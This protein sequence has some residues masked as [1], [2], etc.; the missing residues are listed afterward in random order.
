[1][2]NESVLVDFTILFM[3]LL[4]C[5]AILSV[6]GGWIVILCIVLGVAALIS[7]LSEAK[8]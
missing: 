2:N 4:A 8:G 1:M 3:T 7:T 6:G 5:C